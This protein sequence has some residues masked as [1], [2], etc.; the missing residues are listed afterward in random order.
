MDLETRARQIKVVATD[1][2]GVLTDGRLHYPV[3]GVFTA[4]HSTS[5]MGQQLSGFRLNRSP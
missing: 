4:K 1:V 2:D 3:E 5:A